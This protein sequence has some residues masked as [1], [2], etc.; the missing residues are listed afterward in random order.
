MQNAERM[1]SVAFCID[2]S[3]FIPMTDAAPS[4][5]LANFRGSTPEQLAYIVE[6]MR[7]MSLQTD[8]QKMVQA[9]G[10]RVRKLMATDRFISLSRRDLK[11]PQVM[12]TRNSKSDQSINPWYQRDQFPIL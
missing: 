7:E 2:R 10:S 9:Y 4:T 11:K 8:P 12:I 5:L 1:Q 3:A 6:T